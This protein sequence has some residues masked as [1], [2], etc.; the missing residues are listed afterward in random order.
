MAL[1]TSLYTGLTGMKTNSQMLDVVGNNISNVNTTG[2]KRSRATFETQISQTLKNGSAP[3]A[4]L[5]GTNPAQVGLGVRLASITRDF[6]G[7]GLQP[8]GVATHM[9]VEGNGFF[10]VSEGGSQRF[11][12]D[13]TFS[14]DRDF[15]LVTS[16]GSKVQG[17]GVDDDY[18]VV[19]GLLQDINIPIGVLTIAEATE[20]VN[21]AGNL[22]AGGDAA[23]LGS[24]LE[25][26]ALFSDAAA[27]TAATAATALTSIFNTSGTALF[28]TGDVVTLTGLSRGGANIADKTFEIGTNLA[29]ADS[30]GASLGDFVTFLQDV[31][32]IDTTQ[33]G[34][35]GVSINATGQL[36]VEANIGTANA[37]DID[38]GDIVVNQ[39][40]T[41]TVPLSWTQTQEATGESVRTTFIAYDSLGNPLEIDL[42]AVL[43]VKDNTGTQWR[44]Y[45]HSEDDTDLNKFLG[46]GLLNFDTDGQFVSS[47]SNALTIDRLATG[48]LNPQSINLNFTDQFGAVTALTDVRSQIS[49]ISQ[50]GTPIGTLEDFS[51][52][53]DGVLVG[54]F[55]N[56]LLRNLGR[57]PLAMFSNNEGLL[58][59]GGNLYTNTSNSGTPQIVNPG[60]GG[61]GRIVGRAVELSNV[62]LAEEFINLIS[63]QTGFSANS[64]VISTSDQLIQ[65][66]LA[67]IR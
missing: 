3:S 61:S 7:G 27:T 24:I 63:A 67:T 54:V 17:F 48:A 5:G 35:P 16:S 8:T 26:A 41:P 9:A 47:T 6:S 38:V 49:S 1:T 28:T 56:S 45:T 11:T 42:T 52:S 19:E 33:T 40:T 25:S 20:N 57:V 18:E 12:R 29:G 37:I 36:V 31:L 10:V 13:G 53:E 50:D 51:V 39:S 46:T 2:F 15:N 43:E 32:G 55:S 14:L 22:N 66:L 23:T 64:R 44:F 4:E 21:M 62:D 59:V 65:E 34:T 30:F 58:E 60:S